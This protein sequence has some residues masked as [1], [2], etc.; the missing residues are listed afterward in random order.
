MTQEYLY[1]IA[2]YLFERQQMKSIFQ[3]IA[4]IKWRQRM[5]SQNSTQ[6]KSNSTLIYGLE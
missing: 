2:G 1:I 3:A 4:H 5:R 6:I